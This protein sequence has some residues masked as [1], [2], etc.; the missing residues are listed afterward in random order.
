MRPTTL[1]GLALAALL[2]S[3]CG[4]TGVDRELASCPPG[5]LRPLNSTRWH[6]QDQPG[7]AAPTKVAA[8]TIGGGPSTRGGPSAG[9]AE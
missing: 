4:A 9:S 7:I 3:A 6:W 8:T 5:D 1:S 2:L